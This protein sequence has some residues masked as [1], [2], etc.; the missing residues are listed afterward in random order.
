DLERAEPSL[1]ER[2][3]LADGGTALRS[4]LHRLL[5]PAVEADQ[6]A[7]DVPVV[8]RVEDLYEVH[9]IRG[10]RVVEHDPDPVAADVVELAGPPRGVRVAV[11]R[12]GG[13]VLRGV[14]DRVR[15]VA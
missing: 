4:Q 13:A 8:G 11:E 12:A 5:V 2:D 1:R 3:G 7:R 9:V 10:D 15:V 6:G 14:G